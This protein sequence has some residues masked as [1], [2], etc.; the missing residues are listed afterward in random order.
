VWRLS[1]PAPLPRDDRLGGR[2]RDSGF[3][4]AT[5]LLFAPAGEATLNV[6]SSFLPP[7]GRRDSGAGVVIAGVAII[8][9][10]A[11]L[12]RSGGQL[13]VSAGDH[14]RHLGSVRQAIGLALDAVPER[15]DAPRCG[16]PRRSPG[17]RRSNDLHIWGMSTTA[18]PR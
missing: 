18:R 6:R 13:I 4:G 12:A 5:A 11:G 10:P 2:S 7:G 1:H 8:D 17:S 14:L 9:D 3:N 16:P 15:I